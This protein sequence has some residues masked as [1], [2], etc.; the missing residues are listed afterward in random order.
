[1]VRAGSKNNEIDTLI[2]LLVAIA[3]QVCER[4][5]EQPRNERERTFWWPVQPPAAFP[6]ANYVQPPPVVDL[7]CHRMIEGPFQPFIKG[8]RR[9]FHSGDSRLSLVNRKR[10]SSASLECAKRSTITLGP[11]ICH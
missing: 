9:F 7:R 11:A 10:L 6:I 1:M 3:G 8:C 2:N 4:I 5:F